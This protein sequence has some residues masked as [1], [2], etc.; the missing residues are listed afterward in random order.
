MVGVP[1]V[2]AL[3]IQP[4]LHQLGTKSIVDLRSGSGGAMPEVIKE[5]HK[6]EGMNDVF[7][8]MIDLYPNQDTIKIIKKINDQ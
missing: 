5:L 1:E 8:T 6:H 2:L 3:Q 4:I 7:L